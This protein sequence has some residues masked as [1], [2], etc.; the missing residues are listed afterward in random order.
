[1]HRCAQY[2]RFDVNPSH[3]LPTSLE[4]AQLIPPVSEADYPYAYFAKGAPRPAFNPM[5][6]DL[7]WGNAWWLA[8]ASLIAY[9]ES[10][11]AQRLF[12]MGGFNSQ[13][14]SALERVQAYLLSDAEKIIIVFRGTELRLTS[15]QIFKDWITN[16]EV[17][18]V[19]IPTIAGK[20]HQGFYEGASA[21]FTG[22]SGTINAMLEEK[23][24]P[25]WFTGH[26][27]GGALATISA[28]LYPNCT[29]VYTFGCPRV[30]DAK[31]ALAYDRQLWRI[32]NQRDPVARAP[33]SLLLFGKYK[34]SG[35]SVWFSSE[36]NPRV[37]TEPSWQLFADVFDH[38][39]TAYTAL[40]WNQA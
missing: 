36:T 7:N 10:A 16:L 13:H 23:P 6:T 21:L 4:L 30:G 34:H 40:T 32:C 33:D 19:S 26:S 17:D 28:L 8:E 39:P 29:G 38:A 22:M 2:K 37:R 18:L 24:R 35:E 9:H 20:V 14:F 11:E 27:Q 15:S 3:P 1:V 5:A 31:F 12:A 25:L